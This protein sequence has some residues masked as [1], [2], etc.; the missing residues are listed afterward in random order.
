MDDL[1][2][3]PK[4]WAVWAAIWLGLMLSVENIYVK[5]KLLMQ[6]SE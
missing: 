3:N 2:K 5:V 1:N 4:F 6:L